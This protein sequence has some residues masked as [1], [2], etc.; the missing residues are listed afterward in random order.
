MNT[1][2]YVCVN[3]QME[4]HISDQK[5]L[6]AGSMNEHEFAQVTMSSCPSTNSDTLA[7]RLYLQ[8]LAQLKENGRKEDTIPFRQL[9]CIL[10]YY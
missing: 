10:F 7:V 6:H 2:V 8:T 3:W 1:I 4:S 9:A 5:T